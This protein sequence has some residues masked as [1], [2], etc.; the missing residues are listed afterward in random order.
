MILTSADSQ[1]RGFLD[2][3]PHMARPRPLQVNAGACSR[4]MDPGMH[5]DFTC[6][7]QR[8]LASTSSPVVVL[9]FILRFLKNNDV[10]MEASS[11]EA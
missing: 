4:A 9:F 5:I 3:G 6:P 8:R 2:T 11:P 1:S 7:S 10:R